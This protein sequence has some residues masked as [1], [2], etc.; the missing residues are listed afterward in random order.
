MQNN[1]KTGVINTYNDEDVSSE[2]VPFGDIL[3]TAS[4][5]VCMEAISQIR[6]I[7]NNLRDY[8]YLVVTGGSGDA[9][10]GYI[11]EYFSK[12]HGLEIIAANRNTNIPQIFSNVRGYYL[13]CVN[14]LNRS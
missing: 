1:L 13:Y 9:W 10:F 3:E 5:N 12:M 14:S 8:K 11:K 2:E 6:Q 7:Y 4:R